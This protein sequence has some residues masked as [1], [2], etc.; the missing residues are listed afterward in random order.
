MSRYGSSNYGPG[1]GPP[2]I[3]GMHTLKVDNISYR[4]GVEELR[5]LFDRYG[6][7]GD[8]YIPRDIRTNESRGFGFVRFFDRRDAEDAMD[9]MDR[10][11]VDGRELRVQFAER[12]RPRN[13]RQYFTDRYSGPPPRSRGGRYDDYGYDNRRRGGGRYD[14]YDSYD[15]EEGAAVAPA[16]V[17][18]APAPVP[19]HP[20]G[21][22]PL[23]GRG[24]GHVR[25][26]TL[27]HPASGG[28]DIPEAAA[29]R[30]GSRPRR[31]V[32]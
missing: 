10:E 30:L 4:C 19:D 1:Q 27:A 18:D 32:I 6:D 28:E 31:D 11:V 2:D 23:P 17:P 20:K 14:D 8:V 3:S 24:R 29:T 21:A 25:P 5:R 13:P 7:I 22:T 9:A 15:A 16:T 26:A 12:D